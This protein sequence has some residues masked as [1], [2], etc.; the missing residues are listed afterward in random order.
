M[1][2]ADLWSL[3]PPALR[4]DAAHVAQRSAA[5]DCG[6]HFCP[7]RSCLHVLTPAAACS[8]HPSHA[9]TALL[10][11]KKGPESIVFEV[12]VSTGAVT[13]LRKALKLH[14]HVISGIAHDPTRRTVHL[15]ASGAST[16]IHNLALVDERLSYVDNSSLFKEVRSEHDDSPQRHLSA[17]GT[18]TCESQNCSIPGGG[19]GGGHPE[20]ESEAPV[21]REALRNVWNLV[22]WEGQGLLLAIAPRDLGF[23]TSVL[24]VHAGSGRAEEAA[25]YQGS[26]IQGIFTFDRNSEQYYFVT[27]AK[28]HR[29]LVTF[30][31]PTRSLSAKSLSLDNG[32]LVGLHYDENKCRLLAV[33]LRSAGVLTVQ[34]L[35]LSAAAVHPTEIVSLTEA[36][37]RKAKAFELVGMTSLLAAHDGTYLIC[38]DPRSSTINVYNMDADHWYAMEVLNE[39]VVSLFGRIR[40]KPTVSSISPVQVGMAGSST[41]TVL[42]SDFGRADMSARVSIGCIDQQILWTSDSSL[43][44]KTVPSPLKSAGYPLT[45]DLV[46]QSFSTGIKLGYVPSFNHFEPTQ[47]SVT[48]GV[49][50][51][52]HGARFGAGPFQCK[53]EGA[54]YS[55]TTD[56]HVHP[57]DDAVC[58][59]PGSMRLDL[60]TC[61]TPTWPY[62]EL[63]SLDMLDNGNLIKRDTN[64][65]FSFVAG[66]PA[67]VVIIHSPTTVFGG[68]QF[69]VQVALQDVGG[70][71]V[72]TYGN[73]FRLQVFGWN[74]SEWSE[75]LWGPGFAQGRSVESG[76]NGSANFSISI[77]RH[78]N[79][80]LKVSTEE[81]YCTQFTCSE[82]DLNWLNARGQGCE[83]YGPGG[84]ND[85]SAQGWEG[86]PCVWDEACVPCACRCLEQCDYHSNDSPLAAYGI[87]PTDP[88]QNATF[89]HARR[90]RVVLSACLVVN[91][92]IEV[93]VGERAML[94]VIAPDR[95]LAANLLAPQPRVKVMDSGGNLAVVP[96]P[97]SVSVIGAASWHGSTVNATDGIA[98]FTDIRIFDVGWFSLVFQVEEGLSAE[99]TIHVC[100]SSPTFLYNAGLYPA[101]SYVS[102]QPQQPSPV[103]WILDEGGN[104]IDQ[105]VYCVQDAYG[106]R[107][108]A[109]NVTI[110]AS[111]NSS[112]QMS[113]VDFVLTTSLELTDNSHQTLPD[114]YTYPDKIVTSSESKMI[115]YVVSEHGVAVSLGH[116]YGTTTVT[117]LGLGTTPVCPGN[118]SGHGECHVGRCICLNSWRGVGCQLPDESMS[119]S[120]GCPESSLGYFESGKCHCLS[121]S[122]MNV[123]TEQVGTEASFSDLLVDKSGKGYV[124][125]FHADGL[126]PTQSLAF[127]IEP[128]NATHLYVVAHPINGSGGEGLF[129]NPVVEIRDAGKNLV[130]SDLLGGRRN[131]T[132]Q[133]EGNLNGTLSG[134]LMS[135]AAEGRAIFV[136]LSVD[137][138]SHNLSY[139]LKF[140]S[141]GLNEAYSQP[142]YIVP[143]SPH[144]LAMIHQPDGARGGLPLALQPQVQLSDQGGNRVPTSG[145]FWTITAK[146]HNVSMLG[147]LSIAF[148]DGVAT[149]SNL[150]IDTL[151]RTYI[152]FDTGK[153]VQPVDSE[154]FM[155]TAGPPAIIIILVQ[156]GNGIGGL[157][158]RQ[159]RIQ[160]LDGGGNLIQED[161]SVSVNAKST[162][163]TY[164][165]GLYESNASTLDFT[166]LGVYAPAPD[167]YQLAFALSAERDFLS[168]H[169]NLSV[170]EP[171]RL[172]MHIQPNRSSVAGNVLSPQPAVVIVDRVGNP[173]LVDGVMV[174][175]SLNRSVFSRYE[176]PF[177][178]ELVTNG[179]GCNMSE[180]AHAVW[181]AVTVPTLRGISTFTN[182]N[183][184]MAGTGQKF[185]FKADLLQSASSDT[186]EITLGFAT[187][188]HVVCHP[189]QGVAGIPFEHQPILQVLDAGGNRMHGEAVVASVTVI[190]PS[191][192]LPAFLSGRLS[193]N[194][195]G[196]LMKFS[197]LALDTAGKG[198]RLLFEAPGLDAARSNNITIV[199]GAAV[200]LHVDVNTAVRA[201]E[202]FNVSVSVK[203]R[204]G[205]SVPP[206]QGGD[207]SAQLYSVETRAFALNCT[208]L[209]SCETDIDLALPPASRLL[210]ASI[211]MNIS[212]TDFD[213]SRENISR[214]RLGNYELEF[215]SE[216]DTGPWPGCFRN[217]LDSRPV[218]QGY[219]VMRKFCFDSRGRVCRRILYHEKWNGDEARWDFLSRVISEAPSMLPLHIDV[220]E[221][222]NFH[223]C[224]GNFVNLKIG[225][226]LEYL[227]PD[228][229][230][231][232]SGR[233]QVE[234][235][236]SKHSV[237]FDDFVLPVVNKKFALGFN[238]TGLLE[239]F[240]DVFVLNPGQVKSMR[241]LQQPANGTGGSALRIQPILE[242]LD[243]GNNRVVHASG[244]AYTVTASVMSACPPANPMPTGVSVLGNTSIHPSSGLAVFTDLFVG[245]I[246]EGY[247]MV[248]KL[249]VDDSSLVLGRSSLPVDEFFV[250]NY[251]DIVDSYVK[252]FNCVCSDAERPCISCD[253]P[254]EPA[255]MA[256]SSLFSVSRGDPHGLEVAIQPSNGQGGEAL[257]RQPVI[258]VVDMGGN[259]VPSFSGTTIV[260]AHIENNGGVNGMLTGNL[261]VSVVGG[262]AEFMDLTIDKAGRLYSLSF[263]SPGL[264]AVTSASFN[265][266]VGSAYRLVVSRSP[267]DGKRD[268]VLDPQPAVEVHDR[269]G[270]KVAL[271]SGNVSV[272]LSGG[273]AFHP[274]LD[275][276]AS[277]QLYSLS[278]DTILTN[279]NYGHMWHGLA[280]WYNL[281]I[282]TARKD[283]VLKFTAPGL[284]ECSS[285][286]FK[287]FGVQATQWVYLEVPKI[288]RAFVSMPNIMIGALDS[289]GDPVGEFNGMINGMQ[290]VNVGLA[291]VSTGSDAKLEYLEPL[292]FE[293]GIA[294]LRK[295][296]MSSS[297]DEKP[298]LDGSY[299]FDVFQSA[300]VLVIDPFTGW[301]NLTYAGRNM[302]LSLKGQYLQGPTSGIWADVWSGSRL[303]LRSTFAPLF[304]A[305]EAGFCVSFVSIISNEL[306]EE[307][308]GSMLVNECG[309]EQP[310]RGYVSTRTSDF[311]NETDQTSCG[312]HVES[313][314]I[315][316]HFPQHNESHY[317]VVANGF[318]FGEDF[319]GHPIA[320]DSLQ[321]AAQTLLRKA[322]VQNQPP[323]CANTNI[324]DSAIYR[325]QAGKL[326]LHQRLPGPSAVSSRYFE[327]GEASYLMLANHYDP[328]GSGFGVPS[329]LY[330]ST[331]E[332]SVGKYQFVPVQ[333]IGTEGATAWEYFEWGGE[334]Y[335]VV[336]NFFNG[337][338]FDIHSIVYAVERNNPDLPT[339]DI[340]VMQAIPTNGARDVAHVAISNRQFLGFANWMGKSVDIYES[341][342]SVPHFTTFQSL[343]VGPATGVE[344]FSLH[345][346][347][348]LAISISDQT[349]TRS[350]SDAVQIYRFNPSRN[351]FESFQNLTSRRLKMLRYFSDGSD[352]FLNLVEVHQGLRDAKTL[353]HRW[354]GTHFREFQSL[355]TRKANSVIIMDVPCELTGAV[356]TPGACS[357][358]KERSD[359]DHYD[360]D[361]EQTF[362]RLIMAVNCGHNSSSEIFRLFPLEARQ[363]ATHVKFLPFYSYTTDIT[364]YEYDFEK[365]PR[366]NSTLFP[367]PLFLTSPQAD[368]YNLTEPAKIAWD[369]PVEVELQVIQDAPCSDTYDLTVPASGIT[370]VYTDAEG[371]A[372]FHSVRTTY[373]GLVRLHAFNKYLSDL[374]GSSSDQMTIVPGADFQLK[375]HTLPAQAISADLFGPII[376]VHDVFG[377][378]KKDANHSVIATMKIAPPDLL[379]YN[380]AAPLQ[381][382][383]AQFGIE[384]FGQHPRNQLE[385]TAEGLVPVVSEIFDVIGM[386]YVS[387][388]GDLSLFP[389]ATLVNNKDRT[390]AG[391]V[392]MFGGLCSHGPMDTL[393]RIPAKLPLQAM[394]V[395]TTGL[396]PPARFNHVALVLTIAST[397]SMLV[398]GGEDE[399]GLLY[400]DL[401]SLDLDKHVWTQFDTVSLPAR[402]Q[403]SA[404][405]AV[406][407][408]SSPYQ[409]QLTDVTSLV[410]VFGGKN[411][412]GLLVDDI[413]LLKVMPRFIENTQGSPIVSGDAPS[414]RGGSVMVWDSD[415]GFLTGGINV[416]DTAVYSFA[417]TFEGPQY[418]IHWKMLNATFISPHP[419]V[420]APLLFQNR[421][422][423]VTEPIQDPAAA[424]SSNAHVHALEVSSNEVHWLTTLR[425]PDVIMD[426]HY[427]LAEI[428][429]GRAFIFS[430]N[431]ANCSTHSYIVSLVN[432]IALRMLKPVPPQTAAGLVMFPAPSVTI[433]DDQGGVVKDSSR[434][435]IVR[436]S[437][438]DSELNEI[439]LSGN[440]E[441]QAVDGVA[442]FDFLVVDGGSADVH[443]FF[444]SDCIHGVSSSTFSVGQ[445]PMSKL[446]ADQ[447]PDGIYRGAPFI[448]QPIVQLTDVA[449][450]IVTDNSYS[451][452]SAFL[453]YKATPNGLWS[454]MTMWLT[455]ERTKVPINGEVE[456]A[457]LGISRLA[458]E[459][460]FRV[461]YRIAGVL[462]EFCEFDILPSSSSNG[463]EGPI[464]TAFLPIRA[465]ACSNTAAGLSAQCDAYLNYAQGLN[466][467]IAGVPLL[468]QPSLMV[469]LQG[470]SSVFRH[471]PG[472]FFDV[473]LSPA[474]HNASDLNGTTT[475]ELISGIVNYTD[476]SVN[477]VGSGFRLVFS[478]SILPTAQTVEFSVV[479]GTPAEMWIGK[480]VEDALAGLAFHQQPVVMV[481]DIAKNMIAISVPI[482]ATLQHGTM[483]AILKGNLE[484][485]AILGRAV[486]TDL[487]VD[488]VGM[489]FSVRFSL[490]DTCCGAS[491]GI[492]SPKFNVTH[493]EQSNLEEIAPPGNFD[494]GKMENVSNASSLCADWPAGE[495]PQGPYAAAGEAFPSQPSVAI[496]DFGGN[497]LSMD[498]IVVTASIERDPTTQIL[499]PRDVLLSNSIVSKILHFQVNRTQYVLVAK[500]YDGTTY[501][502]NSTLYRWDGSATQLHEIQQIGTEGA[503]H[504]NHFLINDE[505]YVVIANSF[506]VVTIESGVI[507][508]TYNTLSKIYKMDVASGSL[509]LVA[510]LPTKGAKAI[511]V[512][513]IGGETMLL[514]ANSYDD[515]TIEV[516]S[517][518]YRFDV[519]A[520]RNCD[521]MPGYFDRDG[522]TCEVWADWTNLCSHSDMFTNADG[523]DPG[524]ACCACGGGF[525]THFLKIQQLPTMAASFFHY[526]RGSAGEDL[527]I[528]AQFFDSVASTYITKS[529]VY[530][531][532][533]GKLEEE[534]TILTSGV[535]SIKSFNVGGRQYVVFANRF[536]LNTTSDPGVVVVYERV[537][538]MFVIRQMLNGFVGLSDIELFHANGAEWL[539]VATDPTL[540]GSSLP[541]ASSIFSWDRSNCTTSQGVCDEMV[542]FTFFRRLDGSCRTTTHFEAAGNN[543]HV[544]SAN[545][546]GLRV[547]TFLSEL[548][549]K[550]TSTAVTV[551]GIAKFTDL[552]ID[553]KIEDVSLSYRSTGLKTAY[554]AVFS[555]GYGKLHTI[556]VE[557]RPT[558]GTACDAFDVQPVVV[559]RDLGSNLM[560]FVNEDY[561]RVY[562]DSSSNQPVE[563]TGSTAALVQNGR[564]VFTN[565]GLSLASS[566]KTHM[567]K[568]IY[569]PCDVWP[570]Y[571][572]P[573]NESCTDPCLDAC[574]QK[575]IAPRQT[576]NASRLDTC[577]EKCNPAILVDTINVTDIG[578]GKPH[579]LNFT[580]TAGSAF[581]GIVFGQQ[582]AFAIYDAC[583]NLVPDGS[584]DVAVTYTSLDGVSNRS[585][586]ACNEACTNPACNEVCTNPCLDQCFHAQLQSGNTYRPD[587]CIAQ[588]MRFS[589]LTD[590][591]DFEAVNWTGIET[592]SHFDIGYVVAFGHLQD[593]QMPIMKLYK[594]GCN[595]LIPI[596]SWN[597]SAVQV[598][599]WK[600][601]STT[602]MV[603]VAK[604][605]SCTLYSF[606]APNER[607][608]SRGYFNLTG[609]YQVLPIQLGG[610]RLYFAVAV[611]SSYDGVSGILVVRPSD[612]LP[613]ANT[614]IQDLALNVKVVQKV[615]NSSAT[616]P[617]VLS[618]E[619]FHYRYQDWLVVAAD[620]QISLYRWGEYLT[621]YF[622]LHDT[623]S[624]GARFANKMALYFDNP[625]R[626]PRMAFAGWPSFIIDLHEVT[627]HG[628]IS[629]HNEQGF[630]DDVFEFP[631]VGFMAQYIKAE[632]FGNDYT[633][634]V[635]A[636]KF[637][638][639]VV[640]GSMSSLE[641]I[642]HT[643]ENVSAV[644]WGSSE[645]SKY[646][647]YA[648]S[649]PAV[650]RL[651]NGG[652]LSGTTVVTAVN[653]IVAF[654]DLQI[655][656]TGQYM[657]SFAAISL[658][659]DFFTPSLFHS[660]RMSQ[661]L[662][663]GLGN[664]RGIVTTSVAAYGV[665]PAVKLVD[666]GGNDISVGQEVSRISG[667]T[668]IHSIHP[669]GHIT[670]DTSSLMH[671]SCVLACF[672]RFP[673]IPQDGMLWH[674]GRGAGELGAWLGIRGSAT[675]PVMR[676]RV[677]HGDKIQAGGQSA[678]ISYI[679]ITDFPVDGLYHQVLVDVA[680]DYQGS[681]AD[682]QLW[683]RLYI[684]GELKGFSYM[685]S[686]AWIGS[687]G[688][689]SF[690][691]LADDGDIPA[692]EP[693]LDW[694]AETSKK[695]KIYQGTTVGTCAKSVFVGD[696]VNGSTSD[697]KYVCCDT[698]FGCPKVTAV[699]DS[700]ARTKST[701]EIQN[702]YSTGV[703]DVEHFV[704]G[705]RHYV[706]VANNF[707]GTSYLLDSVLYEW[708]KTGFEKIQALTTM[709]AYD[710]EFFTISQTNSSSSAQTNLQTNS[711]RPSPGVTRFEHFLAVANHYDD[712]YGYRTLSSIYKWNASLSLFELY[713]NLETEG[714]TKWE[715]LDVNGVQH[716]VV[717]NFFDGT[718]H[719]VDSVVYKWSHSTRN[720][721][722]LQRIATVGAHSVQHVEH[723]GEHFLFFS[724]FRAA[725]EV[726]LA[727][728]SMIYMWHP[729]SSRF[730][731]LTTFAS[732]AAMFVEP[733]TISQTLYFAVANYANSTTGSLMTQSTVYKLTCSQGVYAT[734]EVQSI[735]T[736]GGV[737]FKHFTRGGIHYLAVSNWALGTQKV[738]GMCDGITPQDPDQGTST[739]YPLR[740]PSSIA[741]YLWNGESFEE[742][743]EAETGTGVWSLDV[744][745]IGNR[746]YVLSAMVEDRG[747]EVT[748]H[749]AGLDQH[750]ENEMVSYGL[751]WD[752]SVS[753]P[754]FNTLLQKP[755]SPADSTAQQAWGIEFVALPYAGTS[756]GAYSNASACC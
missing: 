216:Y 557:T 752:G 591:T 367:E 342:G 241:I 395:P 711:S 602:W 582:P 202:T 350:L 561:V 543:H 754:H 6:D 282:D 434:N 121:K 235:S 164:F 646:L 647:M 231:F 507:E 472:F 385:F 358:R 386:A 701:E 564:A 77:A 147:N 258:K 4:C 365:V 344:L 316:H 304:E 426:R 346:V 493:S 650:Y 172:E 166:D 263:S 417:I 252:C 158:D 185:L 570:P 273:I 333:S 726:S 73:V 20:G 276:G 354:N 744:A 394:L 162:Q 314:H 92:Q 243:F 731:P 519:N 442:Q 516:D 722:V 438:F 291:R 620:S 685:S 734:S 83:T 594:P 21:E 153:N 733:F 49:N 286:P 108:E 471:D 476:I 332:E 747:T 51:T 215:P 175:I 114:S 600:Q 421:W 17:I 44:V 82:D 293:D 500:L 708:K 287:I 118:C 208:G 518:L 389:G 528:A 270:N 407:Q 46:G 261:T 19:S 40:L 330:R 203:D 536:G 159:P 635:V 415:T 401:Y 33:G 219:D 435:A 319:C 450:N 584:A 440:T 665:T 596:Q 689:H 690:G 420:N 297:R 255:V 193:S 151:G 300:Q 397:E 169:F 681:A 492:E 320:C 285:A 470:T 715:S 260:S 628:N 728:E 7:S 345:D 588:C 552:Y 526:F 107:E 311:T 331:W 50:V 168:D 329:V 556:R 207:I 424:N 127:A 633:Y 67:Q 16:V 524:Q 586:P 499:P 336:S 41:V 209:F 28:R 402:T 198:F 234:I 347:T 242:L 396:V 626:P 195:H 593:N 257:S 199:A 568:F 558:S 496:R 671:T 508:G 451:L 466:A 79:Y 475:A 228:S 327:M 693:N 313:F 416:S 63:V 625:A 678:N 308:E 155:V 106:I 427:A 413:F 700:P 60:V 562:I 527:V 348:M 343:K 247:I 220:P 597:V 357:T 604:G 497:F 218:V 349:A 290:V 667:A 491:L 539:F 98:I 725:D 149:F 406:L 18:G 579:H 66:E 84:V 233:T 695:L 448:V 483:N 748:R 753:F 648:G 173:V 315:H 549:L 618:M 463:T 13:G 437:A 157:L 334:S 631:S 464:S 120:E 23:N 283:Y 651:N 598:S 145:G 361:P 102:M 710:F 428:C 502:L 423:H 37:S 712:E 160:I 565:L 111:L 641:T 755:Y 184:G 78:G 735:S 210:S 577:I 449:G 62:S 576:R 112:L 30:R 324:C 68:R 624:V 610:D 509:I 192:L 408:T 117:I 657:L 388:L 65:K 381:G 719:S 668:V 341:S 176:A 307:G 459:G 64:D 47:G 458:Q 9:A 686:G 305:T 281:R 742:Y 137:L 479:P 485:T 170:G 301:W 578:V 603:T 130:K 232:L 645:G 133:L 467:L 738:S 61:P 369:V 688:T 180:T 54:S 727:T 318:I 59:D 217:C 71:Q 356:G 554:G 269:G 31:A 523:I 362:Q 165:V 680:Y 351:L 87:C 246:F 81:C 663:V 148:T 75:I 72:L 141:E 262:L 439:L 264:T 126:I 259:F 612:V 265:I 96:V 487:T 189:E 658:Q 323:T 201:Y 643:R 230:G 238:A 482:T 93:L 390:G 181:G 660:Y 163:G 613:A 432:S 3:R 446:H 659:N 696:W 200:A 74:G 298:T 706:A 10:L 461:G 746:Y 375:I 414:A 374:S 488:P 123:A 679:D 410:V 139:V 429:H 366:L 188:L 419:L 24:L 505:H 352:S 649:K 501:S 91:T 56:A 702:L 214:V 174:T 709:G 32:E 377:N 226:Q 278:G 125:T 150:R 545:A 182:L 721:T 227:V 222:V 239:T 97:V 52:L 675:S 251:L 705:S 244:P 745:L 684:D 530:R 138:V 321:E 551:D 455:G 25:V 445:G 718:F 583:N 70:N 384:F 636:S 27:T 15:L 295:T 392:L 197:D 478:N 39:G 504:L 716:L 325:W 532:V 422:Y 194:L 480:T 537:S 520:S 546:D 699:L 383:C 337:S 443:L 275:N 640:R 115:Q 411:A 156:P 654:T 363:L 240:T 103:I 513:Q 514:V 146:P 154:H 34:S 58:P 425:L 76:V 206:S 122:V 277:P 113:E 119:C 677:G 161:A 142:F 720:F 743:S 639:A 403:H 571:E 589:S 237:I 399:N 378:F 393:L 489:G 57:P 723:A 254:A 224:S 729:R 373:S 560:P 585:M 250:G 756:S 697:I 225:V 522:D 652:E 376:S 271:W 382:G 653:G 280:Y 2:S 590:N 303:S 666:G 433:V 48:G 698:D 661:E 540:V 655:D 179:S 177:V 296:V 609:V 339:P 575:Q 555:V 12:N 256:S 672:A 371:R 569:S 736:Y 128:G 683:L 368:V 622:I 682:S 236:T 634:F 592:F 662:T 615:W 494:A 512:I 412:A 704:I 55:M 430:S 306:S 221:T 573:C 548:E 732:S 370:S 53:F 171:F 1:N 36:A 45:L 409:A 669:S 687:S 353:I 515:Q 740:C 190:S 212:C 186:F 664:P 400:N 638:M 272:S 338:H 572:S 14:D 739:G 574:L 510:S 692:G 94:H 211:S 656:S 623:R 284:L 694:P 481:S 676:L 132:V 359:G 506:Q 642:W 462:P 567:L 616:S 317:V 131:V 531:Y 355:P 8:E 310:M 541:G 547:V 581:G 144:A 288:V 380:M 495:M 312:M 140:T 405:N 340:K 453:E 605:Q 29:N 469:Q 134:V 486:F 326:R 302:Q 477:T 468:V 517:V 730:Q 136:G 274:T 621:E 89:S 279:V 691:L 404:V 550:G 632:R 465:L 152:T 204:G 674:L 248:F 229:N 213:S 183:V 563:L 703:R 99:A 42:G 542:N 167:T 713:Q 191:P 670:F 503:E 309:S 608:L 5:V 322:V 294:V 737:F 714:A 521:D 418:Y 456:F 606:D 196:D 245:K 69:R 473:H 619:S 372:Y 553:R 249:H 88:D 22:A 490:N 110:H 599:L 101:R 398:L 95:S 268:K 289:Q 484:A 627:V 617:S 11:Q 253:G 644:A 724:Q 267:S 454:D 441:V 535:V 611:D 205:N 90:S 534:S 750:D 266:A 607:F 533:E 299:R 364:S 630:L 43:M 544:L 187:S 109:L 637:G 529:L 511:E 474:V 328:D 595:S 452:V 447:C 379:V 124:F 614:S 566:W 26:P 391:G 751:M 498:G 105:N 717:S 741:I 525:P 673:E 444:E 335:L 431:L 538:S 457:D 223:P 129:R 436:V 86:R 292:N 387:D 580:S 35:D 38:R 601:M 629:L 135:L 178:S 104:R 559:L 460:Y 360:H 80:M 143:G 116:L 707:D 100:H 749:G 85:F 587:S